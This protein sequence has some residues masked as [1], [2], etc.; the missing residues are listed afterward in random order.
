[1]FYTYYPAYFSTGARVEYVAPGHREIRI[2]LPLNWRS[3]NVHGTL[4]GGS[5]YG[6]VD[7]I[8]VIMLTERLGEEYEVW[9]KSA[10]ID[11]H[12]PG[13]ST[14]Y[15]TVRLDDEEL[16]SIERELEERPSVDRTYTIDVVDDDGASHATVEETVHIRR[17]TE[18]GR[19][20]A[21]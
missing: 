19:S 11:F 8:Y 3:R 2:E 18:S 5:I 16:R 12:E 1:L 7:P 17:R 13:R 10:S 21:D 6:A 14:L 15:A 4:F 9:V 20:A